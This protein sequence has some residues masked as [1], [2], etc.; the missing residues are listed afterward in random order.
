MAQETLAEAVANLTTSFGSLVANFAELDQAV[1]DGLVAI[2]A[3]TKASD[4]AAVQ[5]AA[6]KLGAV[7]AK[8]AADAAE[9]KAALPAP[10]AAPVAATPA[11][12]PAP[13]PAPEPQ[14]AE[15]APAPAAPA[16]AP[17]AP[18]DPAVT[19]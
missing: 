8:M 17:E 13:A 4:I 18:A 5:D 12:A 9:L 10:A 19:A 3:G 1:Q 6:D 2:L 11:P 16:P 14:P 15:P 7:S